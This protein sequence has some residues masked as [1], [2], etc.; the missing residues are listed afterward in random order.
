MG[1]FRRFRHPPVPDVRTLTDRERR[2]ADVERRRRR[3]LWIMIPYLA[4]VVL[5]F[6]VLPWRGAR[7]AVLLVAL[8]LPPVAAI[9]A[10]AGRRD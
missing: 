6:F 9:I 5:G 10:N 8:A 4:L 2:D 1:L 7:I 3:Y